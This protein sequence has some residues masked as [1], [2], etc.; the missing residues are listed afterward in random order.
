[1]IVMVSPAIACVMG[2]PHCPD[3]HAL[4]GVVPD[5]TA[6][7]LPPMRAGRTAAR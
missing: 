6:M 4:V 3:G 7:T 1:M 5:T 2:L